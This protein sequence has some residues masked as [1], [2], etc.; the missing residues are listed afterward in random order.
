MKSLQFLFLMFFSA[1]C[2]AQEEPIRFNSNFPGGAIGRID[3]VSE[4]NYRLYVDGQYNQY[5]RNRQPTWFYFRIDGGKD[6]KITLALTNFDGE[7]NNRKAQQRLV[8]DCPVCSTDNIHWE[9]IPA[10]WDE[11]T[12][13]LTFTVVPKADSVWI[14][15]IPP[16]LP[17]RADKVLEEANR[18]DRALVEV[19]GKSIKGNDLKM[20]TLTDPAIPDKDKKHIWIVSRLHSWE[21]LT[22]WVGEGAIRFLIDPKSEEAAGICKKAIIR[23]I[24]IGDPDGCD[25]GMIRFNLNGYDLNRSWPLIDLRSKASLRDRPE[26]WYLKKTLAAANAVH[27][28]DVVLNLHN[29]QTGFDLIE[30]DGDGEDY[31]RWFRSF[32]KKMEDPPYFKTSVKQRERICK[33]REPKKFGSMDEIWSELG[34]RHVLVEYNINRKEGTDYFLTE[35]DAL[36]NGKKLIQAIFTSFEEE[37]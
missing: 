37:K 19:Y 12:L 17:D 26:A 11:N 5:G 21:S 32:Q 14:A 27:P 3:L 15:Y 9:H 25:R 23:I 2:F 6:R 34:I 13:A 36:Q 28:V 7:Y 20:I 35:K 1:L 4:N 22:S 16:Y 18:S 33:S 24:L 8:R 31:L 29:H 30:T 10:Q